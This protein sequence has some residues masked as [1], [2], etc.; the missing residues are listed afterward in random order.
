MDLQARLSS[1]PSFGAGK[2]PYQLLM[3]RAY[4]IPQLMKPGELAACE[5]IL[6]ACES[7][8]PAACNP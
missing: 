1:C 5:R 4:L 6:R 3:E 7:G 8:S 2:C